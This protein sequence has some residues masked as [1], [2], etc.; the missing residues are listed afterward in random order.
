[1]DEG[2]RRLER[3]SLVA[4]GDERAARRHEQVLQRV[5]QRDAVRR[6]YTLEF[7]CPLRFEELSPTP[8]P[9]VRRCGRCERTVHFVRA[10]TELA[11]RG[12]SAS[13]EGGIGIVHAAPL[14]A[15]TPWSLAAPTRRP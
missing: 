3:E 8:D 10:P 9:L 13:S 4:P 5:G 15:S 12:M 2:L 7:V 11:D 14:E 6:R 1:M